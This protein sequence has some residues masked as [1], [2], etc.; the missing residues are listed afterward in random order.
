MRKFE[1]FYI[2]STCLQKLSLAMDCRQSKYSLQKFNMYIYIIS[3]LGVAFPI[4]FLCYF[5]KLH[6]F[7]A[8]Y[9]YLCELKKCLRFIKSYFILEI[10]I[11]LSFVVSFLVRY[12]QL[13][14][15]FSDKKT[16]AVKYKTL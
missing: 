2:I 10:L 9:F 12:V 4:H 5:K 13:K 8:F 1:L 16:S 15:S 3:I 6:V 7:A 14:S 11:F